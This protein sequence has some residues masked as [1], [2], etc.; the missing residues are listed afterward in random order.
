MESSE[1][2]IEA[3]QEQWGSSAGAWARRAAE[4]EVG[5]S[6]RATTWMVEEAAL[7]PGLR[8]LE[9][10]CGAGRLGLTVAER[11][12]AEGSVLCTDFAE[13]MLAATRAGAERLGLTNVATQLIDAEQLAAD[14]LGSF[15]R[16]FCRF[17]YMLMSDPEKAVRN[18]AAVIEPRGLLLLAVWGRQEDN[19]WLGSIFEAVLDHFGA[20]PP[21]PGTPGP[22]SLG[23][24]EAVEGLLAEAG[25]IEAKVEL[26]QAEQTYDSPEAWWDDIRAVSGPLDAALKAMPEDG[27]AAV[28]E[29]C[30]GVAET[31]AAD[32]RVVFPATIVAARAARPRLT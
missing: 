27:A 18:S 3:G 26:L 11:L 19:P 7:E 8:V 31:F 28:R 5:A 2:P 14:E 25:L 15:D 13:P 32:G 20:P 6:A 4:P 17:G 16:V 24:V 21:P 9:L 30:L 23:D 1:G 22:F 10:A 29:R 12:G